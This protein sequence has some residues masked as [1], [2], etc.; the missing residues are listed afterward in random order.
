[1]DIRK[2]HLLRILEENGHKV[3]LRNDFHA[4]LNK[5]VDG[6]FYQEAQRMYTLLGGIQVDFPRQLLNWDFVIDRV[7]IA[8][9]VLLTDNLTNFSLF[10]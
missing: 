2:E 4:S 9:K 1:M 10:L 5:L 7:P 3:A 6:D 8:F